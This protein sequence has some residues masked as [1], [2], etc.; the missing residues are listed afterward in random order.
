MKTEKIELRD[1]LESKRINQL[2]DVFDDYEGG[3][4]TDLKEKVGRK[5]TWDELKLYRA[6][7]I[8]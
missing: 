4:L 2:S 3:S 6:S 8:V 5:F 1:L 7:L